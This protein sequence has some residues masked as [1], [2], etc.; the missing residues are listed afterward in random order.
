MNKP[1]AAFDF[2]QKKESS[3]WVTFLTLRIVAKSVVDVIEYART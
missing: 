1:Y 2:G 3:S